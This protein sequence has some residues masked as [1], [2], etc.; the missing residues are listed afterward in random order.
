[1]PN[2]EILNSWKEIATYFGRG[3]RTVQRWEHELNLPVRRPRGKS[4]SAVIALKEELDLWLRTPHGTAAAQRSDHAANQQ[5]QARL[6]HNT[7]L[8]IARISAL[9]AQS[10]ALQ[11]RVA[12]TISIGTVLRSSCRSG[13]SERK[14]AL[15]KVHRLHQTIA[16]SQEIRAAL[17]ATI[18]GGTTI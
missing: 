15:D 11:K 14:D 3:V 18:A 10:D 2:G 4:R 16:R 12:H 5:D 17:R 6:R 8:L 1:M 13:R 7:D 9:V